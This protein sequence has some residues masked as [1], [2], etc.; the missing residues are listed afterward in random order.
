M[1]LKNYHPP[2]TRSDCT[3][4]DPYFWH[5]TFIKYFE[6]KK[7]W[8]WET[9]S[10]FHIV[11]EWCLSIPAFSILIFCRNIYC[12]RNNLEGGQINGFGCKLKLKILIW[13]PVFIVA[14]IVQNYHN[15]YFFYF[16]L[17]YL[18]DRQQTIALY[19]TFTINHDRWWNLR[20]LPTSI[21]D[22]LI[23]ECQKFIVR[24]ID[25]ISHQKSYY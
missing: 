10:I 1:I 2:C 20:G 13:P 17:R 9:I 12:F 8:Y 24:I 19:T 21:I 11:N 5:H 7:K 16:W 22:N 18:H 4:E 25:V 6:K 15:V 3:K 23:H 14:E